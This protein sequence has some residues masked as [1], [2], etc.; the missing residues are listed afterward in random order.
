MSLMMAV[1][2]LVLAAMNGAMLVVNVRDG[3]R[4]LVCINVLALSV[5]ITAFWVRLS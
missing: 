5:I 1:I 2:G 4:G 3:K